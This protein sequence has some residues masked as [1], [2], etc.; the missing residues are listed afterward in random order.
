MRRIVY[1]R[2]AIR[3][4]RRIPANTAQRIRVKIEQ[5][6]DSPDS[7]ANNIKALKGEP[8][9]FRLRVSGWRVIFREDGQVVAVIRVAPRGAA[10]T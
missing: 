10:Y 4:L 3:T 5:Y 1:S 9:Y 6:A 7:L 2:A 8:G